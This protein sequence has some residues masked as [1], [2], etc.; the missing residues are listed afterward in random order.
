[1]GVGTTRT[2]YPQVS[3]TLYSM[4]PGD[5]VHIKNTAKEPEYRGRLAEVLQVDGKMVE[6]E[7]VEEAVS[8]WFGMDEV[9]P[10]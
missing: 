3:G 1:M 9:E 10:V 6:V 4:K 2:S 5:R 7:L 8:H